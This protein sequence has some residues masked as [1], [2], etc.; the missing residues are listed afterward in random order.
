[1]M[2][3]KRKA[4]IEFCDDHVCTDCPLGAKG[5]KCGA[6]YSFGD[7]GYITD[8]EVEEAYKIAFPDGTKQ[9][10][11]TIDT[12]CSDCIHYKRCEADAGFREECNY[13][14]HGIPSLF[15]R[16]EKVC[17]CIEERVVKQPDMRDVVFREI[18]ETMADVH[19]RKNH[20]YGNSFTLLR[21]RYPNAILIRLF[22]KLNRLDTLMSG[23]SARVDESID[24]TLVDLANYAVMEL[25]ERRMEA[26]ND[27]AKKR[28]V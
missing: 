22:D 18:T 15:K 7:P 12:Y 3:K 19:A 25:V 8:K 9:P 20:D 4:L 14:G 17:G 16:V 26:G 6:G 1:M 2:E 21:E 11:V 10:T 5:H 27:Y 28:E 13:D 24:D 23:A